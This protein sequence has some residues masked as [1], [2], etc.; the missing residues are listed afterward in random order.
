M[1]EAMS[2]PRYT[3]PRYSNSQFSDPVGR[4]DAGAAGPWGWVAG[5][6]VVALIAFFLIAGGKGINSNS[7]SNA[8]SPGASTPMRN[9]TPP[10]STTGMGGPSQFPAQQK[11][12]GGTQ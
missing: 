5:I 8:P 6:V 7:A 12:S 1:E 3:D 10:S 9:V 4:R 2:D 11:P